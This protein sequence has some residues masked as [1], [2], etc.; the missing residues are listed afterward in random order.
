[1]NFSAALGQGPGVDQGDSDADVIRAS[2][3]DPESFVA[4]F[5]RHFDTLFGYLARRV[6]PDAG[7]EL[8]SEVFTTAFAGPSRYD[9][10]RPDALPWLFGIAA[11]LIRKRRRTEAR[12]LRAYARS[13]VDPVA[14]DD[15]AGADPA[16]TDALAAL[17]AEDREVLLLY[18]WADLDY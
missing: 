7:S 14:A 17:R 3:A 15:A 4:V 1:V 18:A 9:L 11:N 10:S 8:A 2:L 6:G 12:R 5:E 13:G 16:L